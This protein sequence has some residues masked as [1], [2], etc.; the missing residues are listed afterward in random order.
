MRN[1]HI[2]GVRTF[3]FTKIIGVENIEF[4]HDI[5]IDDFVF[6]YAKKMIKIG[7]YV[8]IG[9]FSSI[10]GGETLIM[11]DFSGLSLGCR[12]FTGSEDFTGWG[13]GNPTISE[14]YRNVKRAPIRLAKFVCIGA[15]SVI[16]PGVTIGEGATVGACS[17]VSKDLDPWGVYIGNRRVADRDREGVMENY[18]KFL[19]LRTDKV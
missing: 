13:F 15:N 2:P 18:R 1:D 3:E 6:I 16:L 8:H 14:E 11:E 7:S 12:I 5:A 9:A 4:G 10:T 19:S 17:V